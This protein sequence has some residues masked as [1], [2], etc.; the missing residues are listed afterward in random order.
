M[1]NQDSKAGLNL[2]LFSASA[3]M[4]LA[5]LLAAAILVLS[6]AGMP[7]LFLLQAF[8]VFLLAAL[9]TIY[10]GKSGWRILYRLILH[11]IVATALL[12]SA[13]KN[14]IAYFRNI[15]PGIRGIVDGI[16]T[17]PQT[18]MEG[19]GWFLAIITIFIMY[20][21][22]ISLARRT[23]S[24]RNV[25]VRFDLGITVFILLFIIAGAAEV[26]VLPILSLLFAFFIFSLPAVAMSR[27]RQ[28]GTRSDF[29]QK[30]SSSGPV[31]ILTLFVLITGSG[32]A[33][34]FYPFL[35]Q[36][37][38]AGQV[39]LE[40]YGVPLAEL[41]AR[42]I[43]FVYSPRSRL[44][45]TPDE[46]FTG[47]EPGDAVFPDN[48]AAGFLDHLILWGGMAFS[49]AAAL[50]AI[51]FGLRY[52]VKWLLSGA[53][54]EENR[55]GFSFSTFLLLLLRKLASFFIMIVARWKTVVRRNFRQPGE[56]DAACLFRKLLAWGARSGRPRWKTE[57]PNE[58]TQALKNIFLSLGNEINLIAESFN[59]EIYGRQTTRPEHN[60]KLYRAW[61]RLQHPALWPARFKMRLAG[62]NDRQALFQKAGVIAVPDYV[63]EI[64]RICVSFGA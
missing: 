13:L 49:A 51:Y 16:F 23:I 46:G 4:E 15:S 62:P 27:Y 9:L 35:L 12:L 40:Q 60:R 53:D 1:S 39:V 28:T 37:A 5:W 26:P 8:A 18:N 3:G 47:T 48:G 54:S 21:H 43:L 30:Y 6:L 44:A 52:L 38:Q 64:I 17:G 22:G 61:R 29:I 34:L 45:D 10:T 25:T 58:Y 7:P 14:V 20:I 42:M 55:I 50:I 32:V 33:L 63:G 59:R 36:A 41:L 24:Y 31:L 2:L 19:L 11:L 57:T 56:S